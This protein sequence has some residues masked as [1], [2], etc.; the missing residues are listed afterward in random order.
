MHGVSSHSS[1]SIASPEHHVPLTPLDAQIIGIVTAATATIYFVFLVYHDWMHHSYLPAIRQQIWTLLHFPFH[2]SLILFM[3]G[4]TQFIIWTKAMSLFNSI[5][6]KWLGS[7]DDD[8]NVDSS[9]DW[10]QVTSQNVAWGYSNATDTFFKAYPPKYY[11]AWLAVDAAIQN[12]TTLPDDLWAQVVKYGDTENVNDISD[13]NW[14]YA[15]TYWNSFNTI[16]GTMANSC[17]QA[18]GLDLTTELIKK[19]PNA[20][21]DQF[22]IQVAASTLERYHLVVS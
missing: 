5:D 21:Q 15:I 1:P 9:I 8:S 6:D 12:I 19:N 16:L 11:D 10:S 22:Q 2:L 4:F 14:D 13:K 18:L 7:G 20:K 17:F 3:Q